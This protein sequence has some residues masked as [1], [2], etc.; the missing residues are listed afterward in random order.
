MVA[1]H[2]ALPCS[3]RVETKNLGEKVCLLELIP[4]IAACVDS[5]VNTNGMLRRACWTWATGATLQT[6]NQTLATFLF[7][8]TFVNTLTEMHS[9]YILLSLAG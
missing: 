7:R 3:I 8:E 4:I 6:G 1:V 2:P 9:G 5:A